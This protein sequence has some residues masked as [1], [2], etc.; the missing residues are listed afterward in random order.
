[1][2]TDFKAY[3][4][5]HYLNSVPLGFVLREV[6]HDKWF[7]I[8]NLPNS[9]RYPTT[10]EEEKE[11]LF[12]QNTILSEL[13]EGQYWLI[14][15]KFNE[16]KENTLFLADKNFELYSIRL[17][18]CLNSHYDE[19]MYLHLMIEKRKWKENDLDSFLLS[20]ANYE[21]VIDGLVS[22]VFVVDFCNHR[23]FL[24]YDGG[25]DIICNTALE[26]EGFKQRYNDW[27]STQKNGL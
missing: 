17:D 4:K 12:R 3:W 20:V 2:E 24:P 23:L 15:R 11:I 18:K 9:K 26:M 1:M 7:R 16:E 27:L 10:A 5:A 8:H 22:D 25:V 21:E 13:L 6:F 14:Y 19:D